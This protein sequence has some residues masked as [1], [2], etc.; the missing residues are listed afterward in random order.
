MSRQPSPPQVLTSVA[1]EN[2]IDL[3]SSTPTD[4]E[5]DFGAF[6]SSEPALQPVTAQLAPTA[7]MS[8]HPPAA[9]AAALAFDPLAALDDVD[10]PKLANARPSVDFFSGATQRA[11]D[12]RAS[13]L[14]ELL[15]HEDDPLYWIERTK[16]DATVDALR[17]GIHT[18]M[19]EVPPPV[20]PVM[21][22]PKPEPARRKSTDLLLDMEEGDAPKIPEEGPP[23]P[24][25]TPFNGHPVP[26]SPPL[27]R[28]GT[29]PIQSAPRSHSHSHSR[30]HSNSRTPV[31]A[32]PPPQSALSR[33]GTLGRKW[34]S[35]LLSS[36]SAAS[37]STSTP[38][39]EPPQFSPRRSDSMAVL[40]AAA[41]TTK[42]VPAA[43]AAAAASSLT[44]GT[45]FARGAYVPPSGAPAFRGD[46]AWDKGFEYDSDAQDTVPVALVGRGPA[47]A[48]VL[49]SAV[50]SKIRPHLPPLSRLASSWTLLY[51]LDQHGISLSTL[52]KRCALPAD[53]ETPRQAL[54]VV[55]DA[56]D[57]IFGAFI[58]EGVFQ[59][60]GYYGSGESFLWRT[61]TDGGGVQVY[62]WTGKNTYV[63]LC[64][65]AFISFGG[66]DGH[67]GLWLDAALFDGSSARCPTFD[68]DV[69]CGAPH[70]KS[71]AEQATARREASDFFEFE[72]EAKEEEKDRV[73]TEKFE[74]VGLEVWWIGS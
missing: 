38:P 43:A 36:A 63:A 9:S 33:T 32:S 71:H 25:P 46:R 74:C 50:A 20:M 27:P 3:S 56:D 35:S 7:P 42:S 51:S 59:R 18:P 58:G 26:L 10:S 65:P 17:E 72:L 41:P 2:L 39:A 8:L 70:P 12:K 57:G 37:T 68:N 49:S 54:V 29:S 55:R 31:P 66:G 53:E 44:H 69:L 30:S 4:A 23:S 61:T 1:E 22:A 73:V 47:T 48:P 24:P 5:G 21:Q 34:M 45:P 13:V 62:R 15:N 64:E 11:H 52:Y 60:R 40:H 28:P 19:F 67:F 14:D 16:E 6:V